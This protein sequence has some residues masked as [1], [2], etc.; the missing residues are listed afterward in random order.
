MTNSYPPI[1]VISLPS[2]KERRIYIS[3][4]LEKLGLPFSFFD[5]VN[6][7]DLD[8]LTHKNYNG[9]KRR[10]SFGRDLTQGE[11]GCLLSHKELYEKICDDDLESAIIL[12]DDVILHEDFPKI[13]NSLNQH[14]I[15]FI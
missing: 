2:T 13:L 1:F 15:F 8:V 7:Y 4:Q 3:K 14:T 10:L 11:L 6:G 12:E 5:A 9:R